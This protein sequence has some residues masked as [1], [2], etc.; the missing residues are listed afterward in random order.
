MNKYPKLIL[1]ILLFKLDTSDK[2]Y[3]KESNINNGYLYNYYLIYL[4]FPLL[5]KKKPKK[6]IGDSI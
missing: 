5:S 1:D 2:S 6:K 3:A 4:S